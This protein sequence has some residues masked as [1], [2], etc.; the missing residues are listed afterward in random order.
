MTPLETP[1]AGFATVYT[2]WYWNYSQKPRFNAGIDNLF[3]KLYFEH[4]D[5]RLAVQGSSLPFTAVWAPG[6]TPYAGIDWTF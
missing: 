4:L 1:T 5:Q 2:R 6:I 3:N